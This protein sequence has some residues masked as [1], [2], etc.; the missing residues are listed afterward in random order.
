MS[1]ALDILTPA[2]KVTKEQELHAYVIFQRYQPGYTIKHTDKAKP[3]PYDGWIMHAGKPVAL[4]ETKCRADVNYYEFRQDY[5]NRWLITEAKLNVA[6]RCARR[7]RLP[8]YGFLYF[9]HGQVL[10]KIKLANSAGVLLEHEAKRTRTQATVNGG[11]AWRVNGFVDM[12]AC[13]P[14]QLV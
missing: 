13:V 3:E 9:V 12:S 8:L 4:V 14:M 2:G 11:Q 6:A 1:A 10:L 5:K 7:E